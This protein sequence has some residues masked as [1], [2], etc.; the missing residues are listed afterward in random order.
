[1][2][3]TIKTTTEAQDKYLI[4][5]LK[6]LKELGITVEKNKVKKTKNGADAIE[7]FKKLSAKGSFISI[8]N[9]VDWQKEIRKDRK[10]QR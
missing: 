7:L 4:A 1:M 9:A 3:L 5:F 10:L 6:S 8:T 2:E